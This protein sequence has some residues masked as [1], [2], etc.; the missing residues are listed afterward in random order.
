MKLATC[1]AFDAFWGTTFATT[2]AVGH[3][4]LDSPEKEISFS[5]WL[6]LKVSILRRRVELEAQ[7]YNH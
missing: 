3:R 7:G 1:L 5:S 2:F 4:F 6:F